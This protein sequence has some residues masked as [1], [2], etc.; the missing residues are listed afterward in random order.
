M[1]IAKMRTSHLAY[2]FVGFAFVGA[3]IV[4]CEA[5]KTNPRA[6]SGASA[7]NSSS[8]SSNGSS[9]GDASSSSGGMG[10]A[11]GAGG[12]GTGGMM[13]GQCDNGIKDGDETQID[14]GGSQCPACIGG[15]CTESSEC[16]SKSCVNNKC[17]P[18]SCS[19]KATNGTETDVDCGGPDCPDC[20]DN[21]TC[22][23]AE[24]C[25][26]R[27]CNNS[28]CYP[29]SCSDNIS[30]GN[31]TGIDCGG[32][33]CPKCLSG[34]NCKVA[35]DCVSNVC[36]PQMKCACPPNMI[37]A[38]TASN[39]TYCI[40]QVEVTNKAYAAFV[41]TP[42][43]PPQDAFCAWNSTYV[44]NGG[45]ASTMFD[46][47]PVV[48]VDW[49]DA[50]AYCKV[51]GKHLCGGL[52]S[53]SVNFNAFADANASIWYNACSGQ[54]ASIYPYGNV[55]DG[56][57]CNDENLAS[58][59]TAVLDLQGKP[60]PSDCAGNFPQLY[61][62]SGNASEWEDSCNGQT[63]AN[64]M[65]RLRGGSYA[66]VAADVACAADASMSRSTTSPTIGF[67]CCL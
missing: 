55:F 24:D 15:A 33:T 2:G 21:A 49:C 51:Q 58:G 13:P 65:C 3:G 53:T 59:V 34:A 50:Y 28:I 47:H 1:N 57:D 41:N 25:V 31:E 10:G 38:A 20:Q 19:D 54:G 18:P 62:M 4:S 22:N 44:P 56:T 27:I 6:G 26:S 8:S 23:V 11:A 61:H 9:S 66:S 12:S 30:N 46:A 36:T 29:P 40:D 67:R 39:V 14:C 43:I 52:G 37:T 63:G 60:I 48:N 5:E 16:V 45:F 35:G 42:N 32:S 7:S 17:V 64:D